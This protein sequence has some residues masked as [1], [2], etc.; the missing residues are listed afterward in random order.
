MSNW[1]GRCEDCNLRA[2]GNCDQWGEDPSCRKWVP[3]THKH[4]PVKPRYSDKDGEYPQGTK[5]WEKR[6]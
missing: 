2:N 1:R 6:G 4:R 3:I 5:P